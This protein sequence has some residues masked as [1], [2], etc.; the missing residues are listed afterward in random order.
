[1]TSSA[2]IARHDLGLLR[3]GD[4]ADRDGAAV[5]RHLGGVGAQPA[6][7]APDQHDVALLHVRAVVGDQL[8]VGGGVDQPGRGGLL[9]GQVAGLGHQLV[10]LDQGQLGQAAEVGLEA[11]D[12]LLRVHHRV[13]VPGR[14]LQ[15]HR[16]AV[17]HHLVAGLPPVHPRR[18]PAARRRPGPSRPR[19]RA[20]RAAWSAPT[21]GRSA[22]GTRRS[23]TGSKIDVQTVL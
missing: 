3:A 13:V 8:P 22:P 19:G 6:G 21:A 7:G 14:V 23:S 4:D 15:L 9:P 17:R 1:M 20:G 16:Q 12:P 11:P 5:E 18:R 2:P 10:G